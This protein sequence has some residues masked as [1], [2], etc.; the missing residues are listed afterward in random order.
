VI[1]IFPLS[2]GLFTTVSDADYERLAAFKWHATEGRCGVFYASRSIKVT[3]D[4]RTYSR[5]VEMQREVVDPER[6][7]PRTSKVDHINGDTLNNTRENLRIVSDSIS[8]INRRVF[9][10]NTSGYRGV[11]YERERSRWR[12]TIKVNGKTTVIG[13]FRTKEEAALAYNIKAVEIHGVYACLNDIQID[14]GP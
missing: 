11:S 14:G 6:S 4:G 10:T 7:L 3:K 2:S 5:N 8:N 13:S 9:K 12:A 1:P